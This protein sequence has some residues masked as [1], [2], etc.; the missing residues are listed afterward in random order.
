MTG[1]DQAHRAFLRRIA[2]GVVQQDGE[3]LRDAFFV[4]GDCRNGF[5]RQGDGERYIF[6][7]GNRQKGFIEI[8]KQRIRLNGRRLDA[9]APGV[10]GG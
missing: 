6:F 9:P 4:T 7:R 5:F 10:C 8:E 3:N 1:K 2:E